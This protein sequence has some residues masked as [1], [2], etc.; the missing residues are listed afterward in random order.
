VV[1][2]LAEQDVPDTVLRDSIE[3]LRSAYSDPVHYGD[4]RPGS[5][6]ADGTPTVSDPRFDY[7]DFIGY[8]L[9][10]EGG[11]AE[12]W[13]LAALDERITYS[14]LFGLIV[15]LLID[16][17][18][19]RLEQGDAIGAGAELVHAAEA[20]EEMLY[21]V[22]Q[23]AWQAEAR[24]RFAR[25]GGLAAHQ[26][27]AEYKETIL[28]EWDSGKFETKAAAKRWASGTM[29]WPVNPEVVE[30]WIREHEKAKAHTQQAE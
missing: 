5:F 8:A 7:F 20:R 6:F 18:V 4:N 27:T 16:S 13:Q 21:K 15:L 29:R 30:R 1:S 19:N 9:S 14:V 11:F 12:F 10:G 2:F 17:A 23:N 28:R 3:K 24:T 25:T 22:H 26:R